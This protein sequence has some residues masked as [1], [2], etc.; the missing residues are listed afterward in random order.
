MGNEIVPAP[1]VENAEQA[2]VS[3]LRKKPRGL[4]AASYSGH[5]P[6]GLFA[7]G[8]TR[9]DSWI[10]PFLEAYQKH[11]RVSDACRAAHVSLLVVRRKLN[12]E[13]FK[14]AFIEIQIT[15]KLA[16]REELEEALV[17]RGKS[18]SDTAAAI[19]LNANFPEE[20]RQNQ[21]QEHTR[22]NAPGLVIEISKYD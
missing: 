4:K 15:H 9:D 6:S 7:A 21:R 5:E 13:K 1:E 2:K 8:G 10:E 17:E 19:W 22:I 20:Y 3:R 16:V 11:S 12:D 18:R 14:A